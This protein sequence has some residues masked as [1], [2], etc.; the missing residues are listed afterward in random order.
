MHAVNP[1]ATP[2]SDVLVGVAG[3]ITAL[4]G[5]VGAVTA[6]WALVHG[7]RRAADHDA[8]ADAA[9]QLWAQ[10]LE[11]LDNAET[12]RDEAV[13]EHADLLERYKQCDAERL[14]LLRRQARRPQRGAAS[15]TDH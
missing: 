4:A 2:P 14:E 3:I 9:G 10:M 1:G 8:D 7:K 6:L 12:E 11:R 15:P 13:A 5:F